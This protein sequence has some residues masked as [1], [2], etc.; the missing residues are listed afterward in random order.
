M[1]LRTNSSKFKYDKG[2]ELEDLRDE[3]QVLRQNLA[4]RDCRYKDME[5]KYALSC[6]ELEAKM[7]KATTD[8]EE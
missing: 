7:I 2:C 8:T 6:A 3:V 5:T 1:E 4:E